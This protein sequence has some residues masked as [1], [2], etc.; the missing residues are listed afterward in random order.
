MGRE[1][2][3]SGTDGDVVRPADQL[4][5][6]VVVPVAVDL[7]ADDPTAEAEGDEALLGSLGQGEPVRVVGEDA[8]DESVE[9]PDVGRGTH[10]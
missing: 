6:D 8:R 4:H 1:H 2:Q 3:T 5:R 9:D 7:E 10:A